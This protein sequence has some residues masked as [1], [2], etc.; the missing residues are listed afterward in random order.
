MKTDGLDITIKLEHHGQGDTLFDSIQAEGVRLFP[1]HVTVRDCGNKC[2]SAPPLIVG[3]KL[4]MSPC[5]V[6]NAVSTSC[7]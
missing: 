4:K 7:T 6:C 3:V 2:C 5:K 1:A